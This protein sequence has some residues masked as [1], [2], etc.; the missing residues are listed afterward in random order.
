MVD[1]WSYYRGMRNEIRGP[2]VF[3]LYD[4]LRWLLFGYRSHEQKA[5]GSFRVLG[6]AY[7]SGLFRIIDVRVESIFLAKF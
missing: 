2:W 5:C 1:I 3:M 4:I 6:A 7:C